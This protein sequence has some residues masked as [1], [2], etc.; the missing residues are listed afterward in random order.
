MQAQKFMAETD[1]DV[2]VSE[3]K[4]Y[5]E[6]CRGCNG[7]MLLPRPIH[8]RGQSDSDG[9]GVFVSQVIVPQ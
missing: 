5:M 3:C 8:Q 2:R 9:C 4:T 7:G 6:G 1:L